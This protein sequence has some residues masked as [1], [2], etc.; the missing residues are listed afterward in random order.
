MDFS[1]VLSQKCTCRILKP[2][3]IH[4]LLFFISVFQSSLQEEDT[5]ED[6]QGLAWSVV[7]TQKRM[8]IR[9]TSRMSS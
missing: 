9:N 6:V 4:V 1:I 3:L 2:N 5:E 8:E 7:G